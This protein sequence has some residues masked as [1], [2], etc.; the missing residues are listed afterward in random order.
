M[1]Q[2]LLKIF[3]QN[4]ATVIYNERETTLENGTKIYFAT[5]KR[6]KP[7]IDGK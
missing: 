2:T 6:T 3:K 7:P 5:L 1:I 4:A